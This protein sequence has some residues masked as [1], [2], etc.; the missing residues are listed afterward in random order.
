VTDRIPA[1][2]PESIGRSSG[3]MAVAN[4]V[5]RLTGFVRQIALVGV[6]GVGV[7]NDAYTLAN[8][9][10][11]IVYELL[12]GGVLTSV[13][14]PI[15]VRA[16]KEDADGGET[17]IRRLVTL[18]GTALIVATALTVAAAPLLTRLYLGGRS[19]TANPELATAFAYL[20][21]PEILFYGL[22]ALLG[23]ILNSRGAFGAFAWAPVL[24]NVVVLA[25]LGAYVFVPGEIS[26]DPV[27][28]GDP[29]L[30]VLGIGTTLGIV[31]QA[32]VLVPAARRAGFSWR[33]RWGWDPRLTQAGG[34][35]GWVV[36]Y[37]LIGV[38]G[39]MVTTRV[40]AA[41]DA[42]GVTV[43]SN[44]WLLLQVP[45]GVLGV[46][47]LTALMP[48]MSRAAADGRLRDVVGDLTLGSR[49]S[50]VFLVPVSV[51]LT[52]FGPEIGIA[53]FGLRSA[54][55]DGAGRLG[56][57]LAWSA[58]GLLPYAITML[59]LR[60]FYAMTDSR[61]PA[62][63]QLV[64]VTVKIPLMLACPLVL[65]PRDV[66]LGLVAAN[67]LSFVAGAV[68][69]QV[70]LR[71]RLGAIPTASVASTTGRTLVAALVGALLAAGACAVLAG[72]L[73]GLPPLG[74]AWIRLV[75]AA[76][77]ALPVTLIGLRLL[78]V[79]E[80][81]PLIRRL[82]RLVDRRNPRHSPPS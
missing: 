31:A 77:V 69:G 65:A 24:N 9:L 6:L 64:T 37:V 5:S 76:V 22:G 79:D 58:F 80:L 23:A 35:V 43:Y 2:R 70:L 82:E 19:A 74:A 62:L 72:P 78:R 1:V 15:L 11:N 33:P 28:M 60:V 71:R 52:V 39:Y 34:L 45:Y 17:Y 13:M 27:R 30:L 53:L 75:I 20:L 48:R 16:Q 59:Q 14:I 56:A 47:L 41:A 55:L 10:P 32:L 54:N 18:T 63:I 68:F 49:L 26:L 21:L 3:L 57:A 44:S 29:K 42:G 38:P 66:V 67:S 12:F 73:A 4:L 46:S 61:T 81:Q 25:V 40:A 51:L 36:A 7:V 8:T 50:A